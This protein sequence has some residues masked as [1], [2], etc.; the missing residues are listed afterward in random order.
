MGQPEVAAETS[1]ARETDPPEATLW[2]KIAMLAAVAGPFAGMVGAV[3]S[4]WRYGY[5]N[6]F[7][8]SLMLLGWFFTGTGIT[9]GYHRLFA[10]KAFDTYRWI[11]WYWMIMGA[12]AVQ[13][14][15]LA[16][17]AVHR[18]HH[19]TT[20]RPGDPH[21][22]HIHGDGWWAAVKGFWYSHTGWL[23]TG[24]L[25]RT[26]HQRYVPD[27]LDDPVA[28]WIHRY[29]E[30]VLVPLSLA[31]PALIAGLVTGTWQGAWLGFLWGGLARVFMVHHITWSVN[32]IC[33]LFGRCDY[34]INDHSR[35]NLF[36]ALASFG[37][38]WHNN[39][40]A[41]PS[42]ARQ[43]LKWWQIDVSWYI[44]RT[45]EVLGLAWNVQLPSERALATRSLR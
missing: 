16:W 12:L 42:S 33:H 39:H 6:W 45:M 28:V 7:Y 40:H 8:L 1:P 22:P 3:V 43:G 23:F 13:A 27:L 26:D 31:I 32:S 5:M 35:N 34:R 18:R 17:C 14:S 37:E 10:H 19:A 20:D 30:T 29:Y 24:Y 11:R 21:S 44:I 36:V 15:P 9:V 4:A 25:V 38:G 2:H 41:F